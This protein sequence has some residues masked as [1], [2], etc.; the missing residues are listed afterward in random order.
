MPDA[1][2]EYADHRKATDGWALARFVVPLARWNEL[3]ACLNGMADDSPWPVSLVAAPVDFDR[4]ADTRQESRLVVQAVECKAATADDV[5]TAARIISLGMELFVEPIDLAAFADLAPLL[6]QLGA[7]AKIRTGGVT[8]DAFPSPQQVVDFMVSCRSAQIRFKATAGLHHA[9]RGEYRLTYEP[10]AP[11]GEMFGFL[12]VAV[13]AALIWH[14]R[15]AAVALAALEERSMDAFAFTD[16]GLA[17]RDVRL[18][19]AEL[20]E[21]R[22]R[23][24]SG[25]GSCSYREPM[26]E[27][28]L[29]ARQRA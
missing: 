23:F 24:F 2:A 7:S 3:R 22:A 13:A 20:D 18:S 29:D 26:A 10:R 5:T 25:F 19:L 11:R 12:N 17:W 21:V 16:E 4:I 28:G 9:V 6:A 1:V 14:H 8:V 27:I 15:N